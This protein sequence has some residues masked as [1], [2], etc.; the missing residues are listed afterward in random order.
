M[1]AGGGLL[2]FTYVELNLLIRSSIWRKKSSS[3]ITL[4]MVMPCNGQKMYLRYLQKWV[5]RHAAGQDS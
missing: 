3:L 4:N 1:L 5:P 2:A